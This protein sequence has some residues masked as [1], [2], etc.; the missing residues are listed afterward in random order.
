M[1]KRL[2]NLIILG[3][4][5]I[6]AAAFIR[7]R[8][9]AQPANSGRSSAVQETSTIDKGDILI[10]VPATGP[11]QANQT[12]SLSFPV[13][14]KVTTVNVNEGDHVLKG[15][16]IAT[17]DNQAALDAVAQA[18]AKL[19]AQ[20]VALNQII[21][22][23]RP[24]DVNVAQANLDVARAR[25]TSGSGS[26][27]VQAQI[28][29]LN[30]QSAKN[31]LWQTEL[32][33]DA[34][35]QQKAQLQS[36]PKTAAQAN[37]LPSD[38]TNNA[39]I[40]SK[41]YDVQI[42]QSQQ[43]ADQSKG[44]GSNIASAQAAIESAQVDL[45]NLLNGGNPDDIA[46]AQSQL[47][48]AQASLDLAKD[49]LSKLTL[50]APFDGV[51]ARLNL[52]VGEATPNGAGVVFLDTSSY[53][54]EVPVSEGDIASIAVG[55]PVTLTLD[56][57]PGV[58]VNGKVSRVAQTGTKSGDVVTY[59]VR[60]DMDPAGQPMLPAM[61]STVNIATQQVTN[62]VRVRNRFVRLDR[63]TGKTFVTVRQPSG[64]VREVEVSLG[65]RNDTYSEVKSGL[66]VG[67]VVALA[68]TGGTGGP[69][70]PGAGPA[71]RLGGIGGR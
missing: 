24:V 44:N 26:D 68:S 70:G 67:D 12:M 30:V 40:T 7:V 69:G 49:N 60:I 25:L 56:A 38:T 59:T 2:R 53:Y 23:P 27:P 1:F 62:V 54:V 9:T 4:V 13:S 3:L 42:A 31:Q 14:G 64:G 71:L 47:Q 48:A 5:A 19:I 65:L 32:T 55:Q 21:A 58:T 66:Q 52:H 17:L 6:A 18:Q 36:S 51:V 20:Q 15:Q 39:N 8:A 34:N 29:T 41:S 11:I 10:T 61:S 46:R 43:A 50:V 28:D 57:L 45:N 22:K 35:N 16:T 63:A 37:N 33:R